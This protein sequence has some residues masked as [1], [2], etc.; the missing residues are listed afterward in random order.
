[1]TVNDHF[2]PAKSTPILKSLANAFDFRETLHEVW[3]GIVYLYDYMRGQEARDD[4]LARRA[5]FHAQAF[6]RPR[7]MP[8]H[9][10]PLTDQKMEIMIESRVDVSISEVDPNLHPSNYRLPL[11]K[12]R[13][14]SEGL[15]ASF[16]RELEKMGFGSSR[17]Q[18]SDSGQVS[19][20]HVQVSGHNSRRSWFKGSYSRVSQTVDDE[21][22]VTE[23]GALAPR[24]LRHQ[25]QWD[26]PSALPRTPENVLEKVYEDLDDPPPPSRLRHP[27]KSNI[28][29]S[30]LS[31]ARG[32]PTLDLN[33]FPMPPSASQAQSRRSRTSGH[34]SNIVH[35][36]TF[37]VAS[38][39]PSATKKFMEPV[40]SPR[41][42]YSS[43]S[44]P[45]WPA[46]FD[47]FPSQ[48]SGARPDGRVSNSANSRSSM[49]SQRTNKL[50]SPP[51]PRHV[52]LKLSVPAPLADI[53]HDHH[54]DPATLYASPSRPR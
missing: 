33:L 17:K 8:G 45:Q 3:L 40:S 53:N 19:T 39:P 6:G 27:H 28:N 30:D 25:R 35:Q 15:T 23:N 5:V 10:M 21:P 26:V 50:P 4:V 37:E 1:M 22:D 54:R 31:D 51:R 29:H 38:P 46:S 18:R 9:K 13:E 48:V 16:Q 43:I 49:H 52:P 24:Q 14:N 20:H 7:P 41:A 47:A 11:L 2:S 12:K 34:D 32:Q 42:Q 36:Q 44:R